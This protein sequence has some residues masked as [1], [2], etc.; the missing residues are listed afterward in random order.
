MQSIQI[1]TKPSCPKCQTE[2]MR[3]KAID[4]DRQIV[5]YQCSCSD[6]VVE[7]PIE[8]MGV[9]NP[10]DEYFVLS[11][12]GYMIYYQNGRYHEGMIG[13]NIQLNTLCLDNAYGDL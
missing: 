8:E 1:Q 5:F 3:V 10:T 7:R 11:N 12:Q 6:Y 4:R 13:S 9:T 2:H